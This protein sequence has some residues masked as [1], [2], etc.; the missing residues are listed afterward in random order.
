VGIDGTKSFFAA[1]IPFQS[2]K[3][4]CQSTEAVAT[5]NT[6]REIM[7]Y[8][9]VTAAAATATTTTGGRETRR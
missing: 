6:H 8:T 5:K 9:S 2:P 1:K 7:F 4:Q 3:Q